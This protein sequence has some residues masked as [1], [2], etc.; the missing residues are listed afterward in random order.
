MM[1]L[2]SPLGGRLSDRVE[3]RIVSSIGMS[4]VAAVDLFALLCLT[5]IRRG[6][7]PH[8]TDDTRPRL[9]LFQFAQHQCGHELGRPHTNTASPQRF[10]RPCVSPVKR[11]VSPSSTSVLV[12]QSRRHGSVAPARRQA[13]GRCLHARHAH[14]R[15]MILALICAAGIF[16]S[17][18][19]GKFTMSPRDSSTATARS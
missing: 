2:F 7:I 1:A 15:L 19:R 8:S 14:A 5:P 10:F 4:I 13:S 3:P 16:T 12:R 9:R 18:V 11:S 17:L 6:G